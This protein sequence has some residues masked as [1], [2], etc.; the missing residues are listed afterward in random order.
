MLN[1]LRALF[2]K[3]PADAKVACP[4][5]SYSTT[6]REFATW[7][8]DGE[9]GLRGKIPSGQLIV[10][11]LK[12]KKESKYD[13]LSGKLGKFEQELD[14]LERKKQRAMERNQ[15]KEDERREEIE[16]TRLAR[17]MEEAKQRQKQE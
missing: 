14:R 5:C 11:C 3:S 8:Q 1:V 13:S 2:G 7:E 4:Y 17:R 10:A 12:C 6:F 9:R 15:H 16:N